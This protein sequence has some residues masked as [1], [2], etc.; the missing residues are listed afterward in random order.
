MLPTA[1]W[2]WHPCPRAAAPTAKALSFPPAAHGWEAK[3]GRETLGREKA[4]CPCS[5]PTSKQ[6]ETP[7]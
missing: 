7:C 6:P 1:T 5:P 3:G 4:Q 2:G